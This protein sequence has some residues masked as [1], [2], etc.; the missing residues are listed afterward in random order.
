MLEEYGL[1]RANCYPSLV[2]LLYVTMAR[3]YLFNDSV[4]N[5]SDYSVEQQEDDRIIKYKG[6]MELICLELPRRMT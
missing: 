2:Y 6:N 5:I 4:K 1:N 3:V